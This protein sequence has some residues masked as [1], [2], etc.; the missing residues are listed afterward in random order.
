MELVCHHS[1][2]CTCFNQL[3]SAR[4]GRFLLGI[5]VQYD[6]EILDLLPTKCP[7]L[8]H[9]SIDNRNNKL[10]YDFV[11]KLERRC[12]LHTCN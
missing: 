12:K 3:S 10:N 1:V 4:R 7:N 8:V 11:L 5:G 6:N 9:L 2:C